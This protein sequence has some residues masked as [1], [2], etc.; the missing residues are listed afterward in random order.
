MNKNEQNSVLA[1]KEEDILA[2]LLGEYTI[3]TKTFEI[4]RLGIRIDL[5]GLT[6]KELKAL[7]KE[8]M[9]KPKKVNGRWE[10]KV[11]GDDY[12][13]AIIAASTTNFDWNNSKLVEKYQVGDGKK[14]V[15]KRLLPGERSFLVTKA[16]ELSGYNDDIEEV[17]EDDI[18]NS[19]VG[20]E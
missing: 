9:M 8:C 14:V 5:K 2:K 16:L 3:P 17:D 12:D 13:A 7:K 19:S 18:K 1:M 20:E 10:E 6:D 15:L 4:K 11:N